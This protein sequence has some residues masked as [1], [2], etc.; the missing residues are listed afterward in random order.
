VLKV[1]SCQN[2][3]F[4]LVLP[5]IIGFFCQRLAF[6]GITNYYFITQLL[7]SLHNS[8]FDVPLP[9]SEKVT[10]LILFSLFLE[11]NKKMTRE[12]L[13]EKT[14]NAL[15]KLPDKKL[16]EVSDFAEFLNNK[17]E[18]RKLTEEIQLIGAVS[19]SFRFLEED[20]DLYSVSDLKERYK[21]KREILF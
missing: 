20:E 18:D 12:K 15:S 19:K 7:Y 4:C 17:T 10:N 14:M 11:K 6:G 5:F 3:S 2:L 9:N 21:L 1:F 16:K 13:M 8:F